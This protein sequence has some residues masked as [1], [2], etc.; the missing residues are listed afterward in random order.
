MCSSALECEQVL[1]EGA[2]EHHRVRAHRHVLSRAWGQAGGHVL[3]QPSING[4][5]ALG[6]FILDTGVEI[7]PMSSCSSAP[8]T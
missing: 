1:E 7:L 2:P 8:L 6:F 5:D 4:R 3:V